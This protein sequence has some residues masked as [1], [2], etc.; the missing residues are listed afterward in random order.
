[1]KARA[2]PPRMAV[3]VSGLNLPGARTAAIRA[4]MSEPCAKWGQ[5]VPNMTRSAPAASTSASRAG[6]PGSSAPRSAYT[7]GYSPIRAPASAACSG[8]K[9]RAPACAREM[10]I[11]GNASK[12]RRRWPA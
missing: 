4:A 12:V 6:E 11:D 8:V 2:L 9:V 5:S 3:A 7:C 1:M 10:L